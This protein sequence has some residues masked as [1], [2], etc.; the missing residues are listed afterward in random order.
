MN[1]NLSQN[2]DPEIVNIRKKSGADLGYDPQG[3]KLK[4]RYGQE[5]DKT[6]QKI[7]SKILTQNGLQN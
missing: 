3:Q 4:G 6:N 7:R 1:G 5:R 2:Q